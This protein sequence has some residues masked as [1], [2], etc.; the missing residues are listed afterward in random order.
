[1]YNHI[2]CGVVILLLIMD[3]GFSQQPPKAQPNLGTRTSVATPQNKSAASSDLTPEAE[4]DRRAYRLSQVRFFA[5]RVLG[6]KSTRASVLSLLYFADLLWKD[7]ETYAR[8][9]F[10]KAYEKTDWSRTPPLK[11]ASKKNSSES[12][13]PQLTTAEL[14]SLRSRVIARI[15]SRDA[16][17]AKKL[18]DQDND[19]GKNNS[20]SLGSAEAFWD[21]ALRS[22]DKDIKKV[23]D[24]AEKSL[25][26][27][28]PH[29]FVFLLDKIRNK[30]SAVA[31]SL[32]LI[33]LERLAA[34][35]SVNANDLLELGVYVFMS[36]I[37]DLTDYGLRSGDIHMVRV[38][39]FGVV[40]IMANRP[41]V[42][43]LIVREYLNTAIA[44]LLRGAS[45]PRQKQLYYI[46]AYQL[47]PKAA[48]FLPERAP[49]LL[50]LMNN[51]AA[52]IHPSLLD[53]S[54]FDSL[55]RTTAST[56]RTLD[57]ALEKIEKIVGDDR[58]DTECLV[59][60]HTF[61]ARRDLAGARTLA[62]KISRSS[63]RDKL[64]T[65]MDFA[66][67]LK[68]V[69]AG[70][71]AG[72]EEKA[73]KLKTGIEQA[74]LWLT[75]VNR[76]TERGSSAKA[77]QALETAL[78]KAERLDDIRSAYLLVAVAGE[79]ARSNKAMAAY[80]L[81]EAI[82]RFNKDEP[83]PLTSVRWAQDVEA[84]TV[85]RSFPLTAKGVDFDFNKMMAASVSVGNDLE[86]AIA[87]VFDLKNEE[88]L[89]TAL[90]AISVALLK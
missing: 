37:T 64:I 80:A 83:P 10:V 90:I 21:A 52:N 18:A 14:K 65:Q 12:D 9:L 15:A 77:L 51:A 28:V 69:E 35:P 29:G 71:L 11:D 48:E 85:S 13:E 67:A 87:S 86:W 19:S 82:K 62:E 25:S 56:V 75:I 27:G 45:D 36:P 39:N 43:P 44:V 6:F 78:I 2:A 3:R 26:F 72:A 73:A 79:Y 20:S 59:L 63:T 58:R 42:S 74:L 54:A 49:E 66:D 57:E 38:G 33:A 23:I 16:K 30:E 61:Y 31:D 32:F 60:A 89:A 41:G 8:G 1:M 5:D 4:K 53:R 84:G 7:D 17:L 50:A 88:I 24:L 22:S 81:G 40:N 47:L 34:Q 68:M 55:A 76:W 70:D 46:A